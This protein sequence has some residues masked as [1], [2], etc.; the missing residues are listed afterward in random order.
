MDYNEIAV[1]AVD[2]GSIKKGNFGWCRACI[3][4]KNM[5]TNTSINELIESICVDINSG[6][7][8]ALGFECPL[9]LNLP[10][11]PDNL[12][13]ARKGEGDR[14]WCA[15]A[16]CGALAVGLVESAWILEKISKRSSCRIIPSLNWENFTSSD[17]NLFL[18]EAFVSSKAK[19]TSHEDDA[20]IAVKTFMAA[21]PNIGCASAIRNDNPYSLIGAAILRAGLSSDANLLRHDCIVIKTII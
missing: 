12:T 10:E 11:S 16:G 17:A 6:A 13:S 9:T 15:G 14:A 1:F 8:V 20:M 3:S 7:K 21:Y 18:W 4:N 19:G 5:Y 2:V